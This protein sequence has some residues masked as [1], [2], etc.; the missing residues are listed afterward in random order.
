MAGSY[1]L[2]HRDLFEQ[3]DDIFKDV[4]HC[5]QSVW[6]YKEVNTYDELWTAEWW[7]KQQEMCG[8][9]DILSLLMYIDETSITMTGRNV[10]PVYFT[11]GN[12]P[13]HLRRSINAKRI[14]GYVPVVKTIKA[15]KSR[16][17]VKEFKRK[18]HHFCLRWLL[19]SVVSAWMVKVT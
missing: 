10:Y 4:E 8:D 13:L 17:K 18:L 16:P 6:R 11:V 2:L 19:S 15:Y 5:K 3:I 1:D 14:L 12:L 7:K 9:M